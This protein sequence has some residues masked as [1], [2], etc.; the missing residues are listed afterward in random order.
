MSR[1]LELLKDRIDY[2]TILRLLG[3]PY[4]VAE[5][6]GCLRFRCLNPEHEDRD[7]SMKVQ[8]RTR[9]KAKAGRWRC[10][11]NACTAWGRDIF[12]LIRVMR[13]C[14]MREAVEFASG[15]S[16]QVSGTEILR[17]LAVED[18]GTGFQPP[19]IRTAER[20]FPQPTPVPSRPVDPQHYY[21]ME[22]RSPPLN[23][24][25]ACDD[26]AVYVTAG[27][28]E[29]YMA[30]PV[31]WKDGTQV[32]FQCF[33]I[34]DDARAKRRER[35]PRKSDSKKLF[36]PR[37]PIDRVIFGIERMRL[38]QPCILTEGVF[39]S[40]RCRDAVARAGADFACLSPL[41]NKFT[42]GSN[43]G[44][45]HYALLRS[46]NPPEIV[47]IPDQKGAE[48]SGDQ[49]VLD[50][51][52][53]FGYETRVTIAT[54]PKGEDPDSAGVVAILRALEART[55]YAR[56]AIDRAAGPS[57]RPSLADLV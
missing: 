41:S 43:Y 10:W 42:Q 13:R 40:W 23:P 37:A 22:R 18:I 1:E 27:E 35:F 52:E 48:G 49:L 7:P 38:N 36:P 17:A 6:E 12:D 56:W 39:D 8:F 30:V 21:F 47:I 32:T 33:A 4:L 46:Y 50:V 55:S 28:Y 26:G 11:N 20:P 34:D 3:I 5:G 16:E 2:E 54:L 9:G 15:N 44:N 31:R 25:H 14:S 19:N 51:G 53:A 57:V 24:K 29:G 45:D